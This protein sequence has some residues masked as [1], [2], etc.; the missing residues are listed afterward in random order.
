MDPGERQRAV[1]DLPDRGLG[2]DRGRVVG[3]LASSARVGFG[4][5][6]SG[7]RIPAARPTSVARRIGALVRIRDI[8]GCPS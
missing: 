8:G 5:T 4:L 3:G 2:T 7:S 6:A 1:D